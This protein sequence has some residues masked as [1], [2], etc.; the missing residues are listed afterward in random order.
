MS[1]TGRIPTILVAEDEDEVRGLI[2]RSLRG[3]EANLIEA[4]DGTDAVQAIRRHQPDLLILDVRM[5]GLSGWEICDRVRKDPALASTR[6][7]LLSAVGE[8]TN[9]IMASLSGADDWLDKP[10]DIA[11]LEARVRRLLASPRGEPQKLTD[12]G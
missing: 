4:M 5:P 11:V 2:L 3:L 10:F 9:E 7:L 12:P 8:S 6:I 1:G